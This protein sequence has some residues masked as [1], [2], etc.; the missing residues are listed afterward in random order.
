MHVFMTA[1]AMGM[2]SGEQQIAAKNGC[3]RLLKEHWRSE[4]IRLLQ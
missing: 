2:G 4:E 1:K 3:A